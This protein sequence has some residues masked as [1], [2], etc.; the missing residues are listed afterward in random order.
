M[1]PTTSEAGDRRCAISTD[2]SP[3][4]SQRLRSISTDFFPI[5]THTTVRSPLCYL[6]RNGRAI[7]VGSHSTI[8]LHKLTE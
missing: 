3:L 7:S 5:A 4:L 8:D 1:E 2:F 6:H